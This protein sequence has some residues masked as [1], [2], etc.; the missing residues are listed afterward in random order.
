MADIADLEGELMQRYSA[1]K[2]SGAGWVGEVPEHWRVEKFRW[3]TKLSNQKNDDDVERPMLSLSAYDGIK[4]KEY[5]YET[6][7]RTE[8]QNL[9]YMVVK[10]KQL[11]VNPM[12]VMKRSIAVSELN[13]IVSP[14][15][16]VYDISDDYL[17][18][19]FH[20]LMRSDIYVDEYNRHI[21]GLTTYDRSVRKDDFA[22]LLV[23]IPPIEEQATIVA[24]LEEQTAVINQFLTNKRRLIVL[25]EEQKQVV[26]NTAVT[27]GLETAVARKPSG[28]DWLGDIPTHWESK[29]IKRVAAILRGKFSHRP[30]NDPRMYDGKYPFIQTGNIESN[31]KYIT[32]YHQTLSED[33]YTI[34]KEFPKGTLVMTITGSNTGN[35]A[36]LNFVACFPDSIVGFVPTKDVDLDFL[37]YLFIAMKEELILTAPVNTQP[38]LNI[39]KIGALHAPFPSKEEQSKIVR[40]IEQKIIE[41]NAAIER[42]QREIEL[43][44][45]YR[46]TLI[47]HAVTGKIDVRSV[48]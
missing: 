33:G 48:V 35:V 19:Y 22:E 6:Q 29:P 21:R 17:P 9:V 46:T 47:A 18:R 10:P 8:E 24:F 15:Y 27:Q 2:D 13:G 14:A 40:Y 16:R 26:I 28:I 34:S 3:V 4:Y 39:E 45:E 41:I 37:Y 7:K 25:L 5:E 32:E 42:T 38:N 30:R 20:Y 12:W 23:P 44:E 31:K 43:I 36:I 1:Y 11:V